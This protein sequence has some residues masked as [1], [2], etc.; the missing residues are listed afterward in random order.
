MEQP[1]MFQSARVQGAVVIVLVLLATF[2]FASTLK[3]FREYRFVG[4]GVTATNT[5]SVTGEGESF[6]KPDVATITFGVEEQGAVVK[7]VQT[8]ATERMNAA[9]AYLAEKGVAE[10]DIR[11]VNYQIAPRYTN[12]YIECVR[13]PCPTPSPKIDGYTVSEMVTVKLRNLEQAGEIVAGIGSL[14]VQNV[15]GLSFEIDNPDT[16]TAAARADAI[17]DAQKKARELADALN[18]ELVRIVS[19]GENG[20]SPMPYMYAK[21]VNL[22]MAVAEGAPAPDLS[23]GETRV[24]SNITVTYEIR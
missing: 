9:K 3:T 15:S 6:G 10:A 12:V 11:T 14:G 8:K 5:I 1:S 13:Y 17:A 16:I 18:V 4:S 21:S 22:D 24:V 20:V 2:L 7:D 19:F 23:P